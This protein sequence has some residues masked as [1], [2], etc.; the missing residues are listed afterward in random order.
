MPASVAAQLKVD[1]MKRE[2]FYSALRR[3]ESGVFGTS[4]T[5]GQVDGCEAILDECQA[6]GADLGQAAYTL[7]TAYGE[8]GGKMQ[9][10]EEN[11]GYSAKR[12]TQV[13]S[14]SR[15]QGV[16]A[17]DLAFNAEKLANTVYGGKWGA[18]NLSNTEP[19]DGWRFRGRGIGQI[20]GRRN[21]E[22]WGARLGVDLVAMPSALM[23]RELSVKA[24][25]KPMLEGWATGRK[26][27]E[28]VEGARRDYHNARRVWNGTFEAGKYAGYAV[29]FE[30]ALAEAGYAHRTPPQRPTAPTPVID[31]QPPA[32]GLLGWLAAIFKGWT[33]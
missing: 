4:L 19:G 5:H 31:T 33:R 26:L 27:S 29:A 6:Q 23:H 8:T 16:A 18:D 25:V 3:R 28:F 14:K 12:I 32:R 2:A 30:R 24:L 1:D 22:K 11:L 21:Y 17:Q 15:R 13:F 10:L 20:T 7:G 9:P